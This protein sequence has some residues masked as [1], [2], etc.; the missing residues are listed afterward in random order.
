M[1]TGPPIDPDTVR[2]LAGKLLVHITAQLGGVTK[3]GIFIPPAVADT[4]EKDTATGIVL[5]IG[6]MPDLRHDMSSARLRAIP[7]EMGVVW[8]PECFPVQEGDLVIFP[9]DVP[10]VWVFKDE[11]YGLVLM[12]EIILVASMD[13]DIEVGQ[14]VY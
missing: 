9:R 5:K 14:R 10:L 3:G 6:P 8:S 13:T 1:R 4:G 12:H 7:N 11:R 2:P